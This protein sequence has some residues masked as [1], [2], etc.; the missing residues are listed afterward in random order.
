MIDGDQR[1][2]L[3]ETISKFKKMHSWM[4]P[5]PGLSQGEFIMM[6]RLDHCNRE[7]EPNGE[8]GVKISTL[9]SCMR[10]SMPAASQMLRSLENKEMIERVMAKSDHRV[11]YVN[12]TEKGRTLLDEAMQV[13]H[14]IMD[15]VMDEFGNENTEKLIE[16]LNR[17]YNIAENRKN[18]Q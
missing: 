1:S 2:E 3:F 10:V 13:F 5:I 7:K 11:V 16:L 14:K 17:L 9:C 8:P 18:N 15:Q 4:P 12:L 6:H